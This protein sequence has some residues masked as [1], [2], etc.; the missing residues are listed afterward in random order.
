MNPVSIISFEEYL[1]HAVN[2][3]GYVFI[4]PFSF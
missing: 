2:K 1:S 4:T 3:T